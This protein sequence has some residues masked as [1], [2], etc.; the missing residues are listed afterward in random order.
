MMENTRSIFDLP[1]EDIMVTH[2][3]KYL[4]IE[5]LLNLR[6]SSP[7]V[8][9]MAERMI[10]GLWSIRID[11]PLMLHLENDD[12]EFIMETCRQLRHVEISTP[13]QVQEQMTDDS[14]SEFLGR[15]RYLRK[16]HIN[17]REKLTC[18]AFKPLTDTCRDVV[19]LCIPSVRISGDF[20]E[21]LWKVNQKL[22]K[23]WFTDP[24][25]DQYP[26]NREFFMKQPH[27]VEINLCFTESF[28]MRAVSPPVFIDP[29]QGAQ[30]Q[31]MVK[32]AYTMVAITNHCPQLQY[33]NVTGF[34]TNDDDVM[35]M[36]DHC[37]KLKELGIGCY[38]CS[39]MTWAILRKRGLRIM[40]SHPD[41]SPAP[42]KDSRFV[43]DYNN[44]FVFISD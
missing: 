7:E 41:G 13:L 20:L 25:M 24:A 23:V 12:L 28:G 34:F 10:S 27:L 26:K 22:T 4:T 9:Y 38:R 1:V 29:S 21:A 43:Y 32:I 37:P 39:V 30:Y 16:I 42:Y 6:K 31:R 15:N 11:I 5:D 44:R 17:G 19:E 36:A 14:V 33:L 35:Y 8:V 3:A 18:R 2:I 40:H